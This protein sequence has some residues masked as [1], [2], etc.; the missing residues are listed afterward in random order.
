MYYSSSFKHAG[1][2]LLFHLL[3]IY[4][5]FTFPLYFIDRTQRVLLLHSDFTDDVE[6]ALKQTKK[7]AEVSTYH[8]DQGTPSLIQLKSYDVVLVW[9]MA[10]FFDSK[11]LGEV[12]ADYWDA[13]GRVVLAQFSM[14]N[15]SSLELPATSARLL[16]RFG[17]ADQ[18][19]LFLNSVHRVFDC[20][21]FKMDGAGVETSP[22]LAG[23]DGV[24][25]AGIVVNMVAINGGEVVAS[26][27]NGYPL[28][29]RGTRGGRCLIAIN[30]SPRSILGQDIDSEVTARPRLFKPHPPRSHVFMRSVLIA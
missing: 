27:S 3:T 4:Q 9:S 26:W 17:S 14:T 23:V 28:L 10:M 15:S 19:Y 20:C 25:L 29:V 12:L 6:V 11:A 7:F 24:A 22:L 8:A 2:L 30:A 13:G 21:R 1:I 16:G 5:C 18:G